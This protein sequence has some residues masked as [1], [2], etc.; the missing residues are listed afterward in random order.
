MDLPQGS[1][2]TSAKDIKKKNPH[3]LECK[4]VNSKGKLIPQTLRYKKGIE[5]HN[6]D[7]HFY[8]KDEQWLKKQE[9]GSIPRSVFQTHKNWNYISNHPSIMEAVQ[10]WQNCADKGQKYHFYNDS[11]CENFIKE[12]FPE[13]VFQAYQRCP[14]PVMKADL[15]RY[16]VIFIFGGIYADCDAVLLGSLDTFLQKNAW[17]ICA[18]ENDNVHMCN[19][20]FSAPAGSPVLAKI[21]QL[22]VQ[23]ILEIPVI[24]GE[25]I[26]HYLTG[27]G[28]FTEGME[29]FLAENNLPL[30]SEKKRYSNYKNA[31]IHVFE[32]HH[33][34]SKIIRHLF[35]GQKAE[36]WFS[37]RRERLL[38]PIS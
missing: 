14:L 22:S 1:W 30:F 24:T 27:P 35:M 8:W 11:D 20:T 34:H 37:Q 7:G 28:V 2:A 38:L 19:W 26:V 15:W 36:G 33:F 23:R 16:C 31:G 4:L 5:Y 32:S 29:A 3:E 25:H 6:M 18:P 12:Y 10:S 17:L 13:Q 9:I 21:I